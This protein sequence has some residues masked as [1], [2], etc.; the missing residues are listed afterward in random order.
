MNP[1]ASTTGPTVADLQASLNQANA[2]IAAQ[3]TSIHALAAGWHAA[4]ATVATLRAACPPLNASQMG[5][6]SMAKSAFAEA[7]TTHYDL[8]VSINPPATMLLLC[9]AGNATSGE[10]MVAGSMAMSGMGG[11]GSGM[12]GMDMG[13]AAMSGS[14]M[15]GT[16]QYHLELHIRDLAGNVV[17]LPL[18]AVRIAV[19]NATTSPTNLTLAE[20]YDVTE[21]L[22]DFHY[23]NNVLLGKGPCT[24]AVT[25]GEDTH[26]FTMTP[27]A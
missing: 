27:P 25:V 2:T 6:T 11:E 20:M 22:T 12:S 10:V 15:A 16:A 18:S 19:S 1:L 21:G 23:G 24:I 4:N 3:S 13:G 7:A 5:S 9:Q 14:S 26:T 17:V 8:N